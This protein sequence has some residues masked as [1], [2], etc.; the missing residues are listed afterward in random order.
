M[1]CWSLGMR[2]EP[3]GWIRVF[4]SRGVKNRTCKCSRG[5]VDVNYQKHGR[6]ANAERNNLVCRVFWMLGLQ[7]IKPCLTER[8]ARVECRSLTS[9]T[10]SPSQYREVK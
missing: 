4:S 8:V 6:K 9:R 1:S 10:A 3:L 5:K 2:C 7:Q